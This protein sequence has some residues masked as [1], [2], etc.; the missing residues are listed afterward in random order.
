VTNVLS[1]RLVKCYTAAVND[2]MCG[3]GMRDFVLPHEITPLRNGLRAAGPA[4]TFR[5]RVA[6]GIT[7]HD[8]YM[9]WTSFLSKAPAGC[10]AVCQPNDRTVAH[11]GELSAETLKRRGVQGYVV[12]GGCRDVA[13]IREIGFP[14]WCR[15]ATPADIVGYWIPEGL[16]EPIEIGDVAVHTG[17]HVLA[18]DDGVI[19]L[20]SAT[21]AEIVA[22]TE[23][24]MA[25]ES[26]VRKA[27]R[28]GMDPQQAYLTY[29]KF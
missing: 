1:E 25:S 16:G 28:D 14:V 24:V 10:V 19:V 9:G 6:P 26:E 5:G 22:E 13:F 20:P 27:I 11:M 15:Y 8:T 12:D 18:D 21:A 29:R 17:D 23:R 7:A 2:V 4:F 3:M